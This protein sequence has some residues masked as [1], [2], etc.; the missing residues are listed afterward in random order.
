MILAEHVFGAGSATTGPEPPEPVVAELAVSR[1][2]LTVSTSLVLTSR[3]RRREA[4]VLRDPRGRAAS[5]SDADVP[6]QVPETV[7]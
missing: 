3:T 4:S 6:A 1:G 7:P 2:G 5:S